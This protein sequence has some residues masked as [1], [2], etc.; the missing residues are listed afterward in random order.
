MVTRHKH[1][2]S[3]TSCAIALLVISAL[4]SSVRA[5]GQHTNLQRARTLLIRQRTGQTLTDDEQALLGKML[6]ARGQRSRESRGPRPG[7]G[8]RQQEKGRQARFRTRRREE[9]FASV[10][11]FS[12]RFD[13][14]YG[15]DDPKY[16]VLD[17]WL[18][19]SNR[20]APV[21]LQFHAGGYVGGNK[22]EFIG[23]SA[24]R[25]EAFLKAGISLV[26]C[27]YRLAPDY[28]FPAPLNDAAR[29]IQFVRSKA[30]QWNIDPDRIA[31]TGGSAGGQLATWVSLAP[32]SAD[33]DSDDPVA[34]KSSR[35][36]CFIGCGPLYFANL[37]PL[38]VQVL[39][40]FN[41][42]QREWDN[43]GSQ[44]RN[45]IAYATPETHLSVDD[46]P[47]MLHYMKPPF[48]LKAGQDFASMPVPDH[49]QGPHD[50]WHGIKLARKMREIGV[51]VEAVLGHTASTQRQLGF[52]KKHF[53][54][55]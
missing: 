13:V 34:R 24:D 54:M 20:P 48:G 52:L 46:P 7:G 6:Q 27:H 14:V 55:P 42:S 39:R 10:K 26:S 49:W 12:R 29:A 21:L 25:F 36:T 4:V 22:S 17:A 51:D 44:L 3:K 11:D 5:D 18:A 1:Y 41:C 19:E 37:K 2:V 9:L 40:A 30:K 35:V 43:P 23:R 32:D 45:R 38:P 8:D 33:P 50:T 16:Q 28:T 31:V 53:N 47:G 15:L